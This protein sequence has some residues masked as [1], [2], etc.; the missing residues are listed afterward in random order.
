MLRPASVCVAALLLSLT[1]SGQIYIPDSNGGSGGC[2]VVPFG[3]TATSSTW[4][5][6][7]YQVM[8]MQILL[9]IAWPISAS[10][11]TV[12]PDSRFLE[13]GSLIPKKNYCDQPYVVIT[14]DGNW[15]CVLTTGEGHEGSGG[16][17][18]VATIS[19]DQGKSWSELIDIEPSNGPEASWV[20]PLIVP[21]GRV[22]AIYTYNGDEVYT[23]PGSTRNI[24][25]DML[26][27]Y[28]FKYSDDI[29]MTW[30]KR[31]RIPIRNTAAD[32]ANQWKGEVNI[33]WGIDKPK[34]SDMGVTFAFTKLGRYMLDN[35]EG[36]MMHSDNILTEKDPEK[37]NWTMLPEG[38]H[39]LRMPQFGS[40]QEEHNHVII[41][42]NQMYLVYRTTTGY[43]CHSYSVDGGKTW[44]DPV[45][46]TYS[47]DG[48]R[49]KNP[50]ACPKLFKCENGKY[51]FWFHN[52]SN[53]S[54]FYRNPAWVCGGVMRDGKMHWSEPEILLYHSEV[55]GDDLRYRG[56]PVK[57]RGM[58]YPD[59]IEQDGRYWI[60]E[61]KKTVARVH[62][63]DPA[64]FEGMWAQ[65]EGKGEVTKKG[66]VLDLQGSAVRAE[67]AVMPKL[68]DLAKNGGFTIDLKIKF[69]D[70]GNKSQI[71]LDSR[72]AQGRG[73][74]VGVDKGGALNVYF[75]DGKHTGRWA[76]DAGLLKPGQIHHVTA[77]I[78]G[79]PNIITFIVDGKLCDGGKQRIRG[80]GR[81]D[82][83]VSD[84]NG[85]EKL[86]LSPAFDGNV[87]GLRIYDRYLRTSEA[88]ANYQADQ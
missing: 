74:S 23:L 87:L 75:S 55:P 42:P 77:I 8:V 47:P 88:I 9:A 31:Y 6:Q 65:L 85:S 16:Q 61:T 13:S 20:V 58:S 50:R 66:L 19:K 83:K 68:A 51:L 38:E 46:M 49:I 86:R 2:N 52:H 56:S 21:S 10:E 64:L 69:A 26:G 1:A 25:A 3:Y 14:K 37:I 34:V 35:G 41:G 48:R 84:I 67:E 57:L 4:A 29:G 5:N 7:K 45:H 24:R 11:E 70:N 30:S 39:G 79:G 80:W 63:I 32:R 60:T 78:D 73:I 76:T 62:E 15:L 81:F 18:I 82:P 71:V 27:W 53:T 28:C 33:F 44:T 36:W 22:Y 17:H 40:V 12:K 43:P 72:N 54:F 59:L